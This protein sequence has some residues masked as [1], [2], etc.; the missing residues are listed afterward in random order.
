MRLDNKVAVVTGGAS[1]IG[2]AIAKRFVESGATVVIFDI[3][4][5]GARAMAKQLTP[6]G[7]VLA[8][9][10][11]VTCENAVREAIERAVSEFGSVDVLVNNAGI[12]ITGPIADMNS[13][14]WDRQLAVNLKGAF[15]F[16]KHAIPHMRERG[17]VILNVSSMDAFVAYPGYAAYDSSKAALIALTKSLAI[18]HGRDGIRV[19]AIC[20]GYTD[21]PLLR[22]YFEKL[23]DAEGEMQR[24]LKIH[25]LGRIG[26][27]RDIAEAALFLASD[28]ASF[29]TG[30]Y[31]LVDGG[32]TAVGH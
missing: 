6:L 32:L 23:P 17:G 9:S 3:N 25:P 4:D 27:P 1:G 11:D 2:A 12:E 21:T 18:D 22:Q 7:R 24:V 20:P 30:T 8:L 5:E 13:E 19:N 31:L 26:T 15:L 14:A 16:C 28:A 29:I 10:G